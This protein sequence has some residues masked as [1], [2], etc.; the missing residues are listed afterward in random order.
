MWPNPQ[1][2]ADL[3]TFTVEIQNG[4]LHFLCSVTWYRNTLMTWNG[5]IEFLALAHVIKF[6]LCNFAYIYYILKKLVVLSMV[7]HIS[8]VNHGTFFPIFIEEVKCQNSSSDR[9]FPY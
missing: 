3:G 9:N 4:K 7:N 8:F 1:E 2:T 5:L 6:N